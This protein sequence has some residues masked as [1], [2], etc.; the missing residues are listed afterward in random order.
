MD[1]EL[2][3]TSQQEVQA[4]VEGLLRRCWPEELVTP[5]PRISYRQ[6]VAQYGTDKPDVRFGWRVRPGW[7][8]GGE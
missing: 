1:L 3:F 4:L 2:G 5:F 8:W 6:A 7:V